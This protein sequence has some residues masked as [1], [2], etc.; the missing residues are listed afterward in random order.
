M[1]SKVLMMSIKKRKELKRREELEA[2]KESKKREELLSPLFKSVKKTSVKLAKVEN[3]RAP[4]TKHIKSLNA[5]G[6]FTRATARREN[7]KYT[8]ELLLGIG[9]MHKS[10]MVPIFNTEQATQIAAMR[11]N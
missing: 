3:Y 1:S 7:I 10:N 8:G 5:D 6:D 11:R 2:K 4:D 9:T